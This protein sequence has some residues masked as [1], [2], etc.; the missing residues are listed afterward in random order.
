MQRFLWKIDGTDVLC[1]LNYY[2][3]INLFLFMRMWRNLLEFYDFFGSRFGINNSVWLLPLFSSRKISKIIENMKKFQKNTK[4]NFLK[5]E[6][7]IQ[8]SKNRWFFALQNHKLNLLNPQ[9]MQNNTNFP[10][11]IGYLWSLCCHFSFIHK[12]WYF[13]QYMSL[14]WNGIWIYFPICVCINWTFHSV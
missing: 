9:K 5:W 2:A 11:H 13:L 7:K 1:Q 4:K 3:E 12:T 14:N 8:I 6:K 10:L